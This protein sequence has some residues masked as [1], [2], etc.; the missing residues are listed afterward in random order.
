MD[1]IIRH[2][3]RLPQR[4]DSLSDQLRDLVRLA[5]RLGMYDAADYLM[6]QLMQPDRACRDAGKVQEE[7]DDD[8]GHDD[9]N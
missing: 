7:H 6:L 1:E 4:Q 9:N 2:L 5:K 3:P 8:N